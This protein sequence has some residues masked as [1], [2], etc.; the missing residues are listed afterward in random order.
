MATACSPSA[1]STTGDRRASSPTSTA[2]PSRKRFSVRS[3]RSRSVRNAQPHVDHIDVFEL[4]ER[5]VVWDAVAGEDFADEGFELRRS[6]VLPLLLRLP[7]VDVAQPALAFDRDV[8]DEAVGRFVA[9][10]LADLRVDLAVGRHVL[11]E[12]VRHD[13]SILAGSVQ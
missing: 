3:R 11:D 2:K 6:K 10:L 7:Y 1:T 5:V 13:A 4:H 12:C 9:E 8:G